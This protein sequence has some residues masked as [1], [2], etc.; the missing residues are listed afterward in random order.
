[1][2]IKRLEILNPSEIPIPLQIF[3]L[4][5]KHKF[6]PIPLC[7]NN[8]RINLQNKINIESFSSSCLIIYIPQCVCIALL[9]Y[10]INTFLKYMLLELSFNNYTYNFRFL[11]HFLI[12]VISYFC[13][14]SFTYFLSFKCFYRMFLFRYLLFFTNGSCFFKEK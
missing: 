2:S 6:L 7:Y 10:I 11:I 1:M 3:H 14:W 8:R 13:T 12:L 4:F 9:N 5:G